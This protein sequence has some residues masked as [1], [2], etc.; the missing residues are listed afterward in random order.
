MDAIRRSHE[1]FQQGLID[2]TGVMIHYV[3]TVG[4][5]EVLLF[6]GIY[7]H[8]MTRLRFAVNQNYAFG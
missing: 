2:K 5:S 3:I 8:G 4:S 1:A 6:P 7:F